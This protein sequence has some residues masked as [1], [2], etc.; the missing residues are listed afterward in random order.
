MSKKEV[1]RR[2]ASIVVLR[3]RGVVGGQQMY[4]LLLVRKPRKRDAW[5][6]PQGGVEEGETVEQA[7]LRELKEEAG[8]TAQEC[9]GVSKEVYQYDFPPSYRRFR[10]DHV[11]GQRI[12]FVFTLVPAETQVTVDGEEIN[13]F[14]WVDIKDLQRY[15]RRREYVGLIRRLFSEAVRTQCP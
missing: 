13:A 1:Y 15:I 12:E 3:P 8:V 11:K 7:A 4:D 10:P 6:L 14:V 9:F 5:Q 2:A